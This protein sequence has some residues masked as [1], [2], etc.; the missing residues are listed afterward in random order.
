VGAHAQKDRSIDDVER[1]LSLVRF[2]S[3]GKVE[4]IITEA[5]TKLTKSTLYRFEST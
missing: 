4:E 2:E 5:D 3:K 1:F